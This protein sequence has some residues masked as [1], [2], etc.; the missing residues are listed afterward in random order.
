MNCPVAALETVLDERQQH[1]I[2]FFIAVEERACVPN[3]AKL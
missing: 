1:P 3:F 2:L